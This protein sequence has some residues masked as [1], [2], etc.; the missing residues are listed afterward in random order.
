M[1][2]RQPRTSTCT[3]VAFLA[4][5]AVAVQGRING[6]LGRVLGDGVAAATVNFVVG[7]VLLVGIVLAGPARRTAVR[8]LPALWQSGTLPW[9]TALA[10]F[11]GALYVS[12]QGVTIGALGVALFTVATVGGQTGLGLVVDRLALGPSGMVLVTR[13][14]VAAA[15]LAT[16]AVAVA[17]WGRGGGSGHSAAAFVLLAM[18]AGG[19][20]AVQVACNGRVAV[21]S[22]EPLAA[23]LVNFVVGLAALLGVL[24]VSRVVRDD[25]WPSL[26]GRL[27]DPVSGSW[28]LYIGGSMGLFLVVTAA[29]TVRVLGVL[30]LSLVLVSGTLTGAVAVD[31]LVPT[32][33]TRV[34]PSVLL[35]VTLTFGSV[36][37]ALA[38]RHTAQ[39]HAAAPTPHTTEATER[40]NQ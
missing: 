29:W 2:V 6:E 36:L 13:L 8:R 40:M 16:V 37:L 28:W 25:S 14:R 26:L 22:T 18:V 1:R 34:T 3:A 17:T 20:A 9:W 39:R 27:P 32:S 31:L 24:A 15:V 33:G 23:A 35:G 7:L 5:V 10:G 21:A 4:G 30:V 38:R 19:A 11:G 12:A